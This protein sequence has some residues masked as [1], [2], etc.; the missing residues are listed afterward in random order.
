KNNLSII[1]LTAGIETE[2]LVRENC[3]DSVRTCYAGLEILGRT[4]YLCKQT[5]K[6]NL[7]FIEETEYTLSYGV[8]AEMLKVPYLPCSAPIG[9][10][11]FMKIKPELKQNDNNLWIPAIKADVTIIH[12]QQV[13]IRGN[14]IILGQ[15]G[16][17]PYLPFI[18]KKTIITTEKIIDS[19]EI[20]NSKVS[21]LQQQ[22]DA[23]VEIPKGALPTSCY[24]YY[25]VDVP[26]LINYIDGC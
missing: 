19:S 14:C 2:I 18:S 5:E 12:A 10:T 1:T 7:R 25:P 20:D 6:G 16:L 15:Y 23:I 8:L 13:D 22:V 9:D 3:V 24:P 17:D 4:P 26:S 21:I 11:D